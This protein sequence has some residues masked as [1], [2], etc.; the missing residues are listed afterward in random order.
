MKNRFLAPDLSALPAPHVIEDLDYE[1]LVGER[2]DELS[3]RFPAWDVGSL[4]TDPLKVNQEVE[5][6]FELMTRGRVNDA[7][8]AVLITHAV[9]SDLDAIGARFATSRLTDE[10]DADYR[11]RILLALEAFASAGPAG[12]YRYHAKAA[13]S[14]VKDVGLSV[15]RPGAVLVAVL[16]REGDG[17]PSAE[18]VSAVRSRLND[19]AIRPLT[20]A[21]TVKPAIVTPYRVKVLLHIPAGPDPQE[22]VSAARANL[23][24]ITSNRHSVGAPVN[25]SALIA[26]AHVSNV[27]SVVIA[28]PTRDLVPNADQVFWCE[29]FDISYEVLA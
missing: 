4:E 10:P 8:K 24:T 9:G 6:Y 3:T 19:D 18:V 17:T 5:A 15:P 20:V 23:E 27:Q 29:G 7:S 26:A 11:E 22:L 1:T 14:Q 25:L 2:V 28:E 12:A 16:S 21:I 13:H